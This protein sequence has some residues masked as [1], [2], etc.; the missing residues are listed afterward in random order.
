MSVYDYTKD[1][2]EQVITYVRT[3]LHNREENSSD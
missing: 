2:D 3:L 1:D